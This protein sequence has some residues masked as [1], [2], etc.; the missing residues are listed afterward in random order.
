[1]FEYNRTMQPRTRRQ[2]DVLDFITRYIERHGNGPSYQQIAR[3]LGVNSKSGI[4]RHIQSL[5]NQGLVSR[6]RENGCFS[7]KLHSSSSI[8]DDVCQIEWLE[9]PNQNSVFEYWELASLSVPR[10]LIGSQTPESLCAFR[11][12]DDSMIEK[13]ICEGD[14]ALIEKRSYARTGDIVVAIT[15]NRNAV[16][17]LYFRDGAKTE[18]RPANSNYK[19]IIFPADKVAVQGI[20]R[21]ILRPFNLF[22]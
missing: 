22:S 2:K 15:E 6:R 9:F 4:G 20:V 21:S 12:Q 13:H 11:M 18:L 1:M 10:F 3:H 7:L 16:L 17:H 5:E 14:V 8:S 19:S